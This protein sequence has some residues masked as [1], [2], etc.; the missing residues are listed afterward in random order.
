MLLFVNG[1][2]ALLSQVLFYK[3]VQ[4]VEVFLYFILL[5]DFNGLLLRFLDD[6]LPFFALDKLLHFQRHCVVFRLFG[7]A[8]V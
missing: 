3:P 5:L 8:G 2:L 7:Q 6:L 4:V 1:R